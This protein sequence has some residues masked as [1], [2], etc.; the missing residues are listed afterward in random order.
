MVHY[1]PS[2]PTNISLYVGIDIGYKSIVQLKFYAQPMHQIYK[3]KYY[4]FLKLREKSDEEAVI[5]DDFKKRYKT[6]LNDSELFF[7]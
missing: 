4:T 5:P 1:F 3:V 6:N 7:H 2:D